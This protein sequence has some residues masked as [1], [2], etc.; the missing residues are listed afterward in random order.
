MPHQLNKVK[1]AVLEGGPLSSN[2]RHCGFVIPC[3]EVSPR[4]KTKLD[5]LNPQLAD[6][7]NSFAN[8]RHSGVGIPFPVIRSAPDTKLN[9]IPKTKQYSLICAP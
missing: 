1:C 4:H 2:F 9:C 7:L 3:D 6:N 8:F 5:S